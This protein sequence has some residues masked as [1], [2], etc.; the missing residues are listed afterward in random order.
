MRK[1]VPNNGLPIGGIVEICGLSTAWVGRG[2]L[3]SRLEFVQFYFIRVDPLS[4][5]A[6][7][8]IL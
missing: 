5:A 2:G 3:L 7:G 6:R 4:S 1:N 8:A